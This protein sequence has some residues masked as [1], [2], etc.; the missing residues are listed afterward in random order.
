AKFEQRGKSGAWVSEHLPHFSNVVD[1]VSFLRAVTTDQFNHAPAQLMMHTGSPRLG[2]PS[3]GSWVTYGLGTENQNLP[4]FIV[5][6][7]AQTGDGGASR[8]G[9]SFLPAVYQGTFVSHRASRPGQEVPYLASD[10]LTR[11]DQR[12]QAD[13]IQSLDRGFA[14]RLGAA[15]EIE[16]RIQSMETAFRMLT[17]VPE[18]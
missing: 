9:S 4:G 2:R 16:A 18:V 7:P 5:L 8:W 6:A 17:E 12:A 10:Y 3:M 14:Q 11:P 15:P 1:D 13:A